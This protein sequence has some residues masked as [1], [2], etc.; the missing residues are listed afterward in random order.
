M[1]IKITILLFSILFVS[2]LS[3]Q[4]IVSAEYFIDT[5]PG[6]GNATP[7]SITSAPNANFT[8]SIAT[9]SL[10][11][12]F[13]YL[14]VRGKD[15]NNTWSLYESRGFYIS[16][17]TTSS[18]NIVAAE[19]F[20]DADPGQGNANAI[21]VSSNQNVNFT[22]SIST[23]TLA[24]GF[25]FL[26]IRTKDQ[27][28]HWSLFENRGFYITTA[29]SNS[30]NI[31]AAE[32]FID[33]DPG[34]G[35]GTAISLSSAQ[36]TNFTLSI[37]TATLS[38]GFHFLAIR[39]KDQNNQ[40]GLFENRGFY[41]STST[42]NSPNIVAAEYFIDTDP[43]IGSGTPIAITSGSNISFSPSIPVAALSLGVHVLAIRTKDSNNVWGPFEASTFTVGTGSGLDKIA[44][45]SLDN[46]S[47]LVYPNP[48]QN[49]VNIEYTL[50]QV[51]D[52]SI[53]I[54]DINGK[55]IK[56]LA[57]YERLDA[58]KHQHK[59]KLE[60]EI[61]TGFYFIEVASPK[62]KVKAKIVKQ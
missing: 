34:L 12:G 7:V 21:S 53:D 25:H 58:G 36:N 15:Q 29:T 18:T 48:I 47:I 4:N 38:K 61:A 2:Q 14:G 45:F 17:A 33:S 37:P 55:K 41:I 1:R 32:Y 6:V 40:W 10:A 43:G 35:S 49:E 52:I 39:T 19:Y 59:I 9:S 46:K 20:I 50:N 30:P 27:N 31:A 42:D 44:D 28:N 51:E 62:E 54:M 8:L 23:A 13:H 5:D 56:T 24:S 60:N 3:S 16:S 26:A 57:K 11:N 22:L